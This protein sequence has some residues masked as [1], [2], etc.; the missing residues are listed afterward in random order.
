MML[1]NTVLGAVVVGGSLLGGSVARADGPGT[2]PTAEITIIHATHCPNKHVDPKITEPPPPMGYECL[3]QHSKVN[4]VLKLNQ[5]SDTVL[6]N[7]RKFRLVHTGRGADKKYNVTAF[8]N[9][10]DGS[11]SRLADVSAD[12]LKSFNVGGFAHE[13]GVLLLVV[14]IVPPP[15]K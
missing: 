3:D 10:P 8:V 6:P 2:D 7:G 11:F 12:A 14:K 5:P 13:G 4:A 9:Q 1:R 15:A